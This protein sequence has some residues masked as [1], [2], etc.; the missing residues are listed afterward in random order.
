MSQTSK[1]GG[2][3]LALGLAWLGGCAAAGPDP[4]R[5]APVPPLRPVGSIAI[6]PGAPAWTRWPP[7]GAAQRSAGRFGPGVLGPAAG[8]DLV[9]ARVG[10]REIRK[11]DVYDRMLDNDQP[12]ARLWVELLVLDLVVEDFARQFG[13][14][15]D[16]AEVEQLAAEQESLLRTQVEVEFDGGRRFEDYL[17][18]EFGLGLEAFRRLMRVDV[19]RTRYRGLVIRY[20]ALREDRAEV[21]LI[22]HP[23]P[24]VLADVRAKVLAGADFAALAR[25]FSEDGTRNDGGRLGPFGRSFRHPVAEVAFAL[26]P[27]QVSEVLRFDDRG[28]ER[29]ALVYCLRRL[30]GRDLAF[31]AVRDELVRGLETEPVTPFEQ[32]AFVA[33]YCRPTSEL[34]SAAGGR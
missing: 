14:A 26:E 31:G 23:D 13:I 15:L 32:D 20:L 21:R 6:D 8:G 34:D 22:V 7:A 5:P 3:V 2:T 27:G 10:D 11:S 33:Q 9:V 19:A 28:T 24:A 25:Q 1:R 30:P 29:Q 18:A 12:S 16:D 4:G 17:A